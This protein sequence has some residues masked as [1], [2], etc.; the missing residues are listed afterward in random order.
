[1]RKRNKDEKRQ[2]GSSEES[3]LGARRA[4]WLKRTRCRGA[5]FLPKSSLPSTT[6]FSTSGR[7]K[8]MHTALRL[9][10]I[11][12]V[13]GPPRLLYTL[14]RSL[15]SVRPPGAI[16]TRNICTPHNYV[17]QEVYP[18][19]PLCMHARNTGQHSDK[20]SRRHFGVRYL[21]WIPK[22][23]FA[24][25]Q[26]GFTGPM[27]NQEEA[28]KVAILEKTMKGRQP[29]DLLLR[30]TF[31]SLAIGLWFDRDCP[32]NRYRSRRRGLVPSTSSIT[33]NAGPDG[34]L[35]FYVHR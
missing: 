24:P 6:I 5:Y 11:N 33:L 13:M 35:R 2:T 22:F 14:S 21:S 31:L 17:C 15:P 8:R 1:M 28:A 26:E 16:F 18:R 10:H 20:F 32:T 19:T 25:K 7:I 12:H 29:T 30:C 9:Q 34:C 27:D 4:T 3:T 23:G